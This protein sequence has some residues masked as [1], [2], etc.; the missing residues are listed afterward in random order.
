MQAFDCELM[1]R[2]WDGGHSSR[3]GTG[4]DRILFIY[5]F[6]LTVMGFGWDRNIFVGVGW[7]RSE[8][9]LLCH[10]LPPILCSVFV[11]LYILY[12]SA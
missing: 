12:V 2:E 10:A 3:I 8:N 5:S 1:G 7:V 9:P 11:V 6:I 4:Q